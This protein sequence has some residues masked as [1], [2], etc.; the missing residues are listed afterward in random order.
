MYPHLRERKRLHYQISISINCFSVYNTSFIYSLI[1][2]KRCLLSYWNPA[3]FTLWLNS[4]FVHSMI[5]IKL[6][7]PS[8]W[9]PTLFTLWLKS[10]FV[11]SLI[12]IQP[13][14][15][16]DWILALFTLLLKFSNVKSLTSRFVYGM[17]EIQLFFFMISDTVQARPTLIGKT[18]WLPFKVTLS[19]TDVCWER[20]VSEL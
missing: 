2:V 1:A 6:S 9:N 3:L 20:C 10:S 17:F 7:L 8:G 16:F 11:Y 18:S 13:C 5:E 14:L 4:S 19:S 15:L 12:E